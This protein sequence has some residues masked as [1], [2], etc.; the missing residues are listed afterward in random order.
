GNVW[1]KAANRNLITFD[2]ET[3]G[4][5]ANAAN[6]NEV[7]AQG[8]RINKTGVHMGSDVWHSRFSVNSMTMG[9]IGNKGVAET[10]NMKFAPPAGSQE[11]LLFGKVSGD[12][13]EFV[14]SVRPLL[15]RM[16]DDGVD[17]ILGQNIMGFDIDRLIGNVIRTSEYQSGGAI[18]GVVDK[19]QRKMSG[20]GFVVDT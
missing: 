14:K 6:V 1:N 16:A 2:L 13:S 15:E 4:G 12:G 19:L 10:L 3:A 11:A 17:G 8:V 18:K 5:V 7:Y 20:G 9:V